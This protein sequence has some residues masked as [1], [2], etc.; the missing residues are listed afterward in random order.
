MTRFS[1]AEYREHIQDPGPRFAEKMRMQK[2]LFELPERQKIVIVLKFYDN[3]S[4]QE[5]AEILCCPLGTVKSRMH[6]GLKT[7][8]RRMYEV[9]KAGTIL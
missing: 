9:Q 6:E 3:M 7:L 8:R 5:I 4:Y 2:L 1:E